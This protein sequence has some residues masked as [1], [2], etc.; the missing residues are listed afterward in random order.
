V[1][2]R[3]RQTVQIAAL[4]LAYF[5]VIL[6]TTI[7]NVALPQLSRDLGTGVTGLQW[8]VDA[9]TLTFAALLLSGGALGDRIGSR[10]VFE[11]GVAVFTLASLGCAVAPSVAT[12]VAFR[13]SQGAGAALS[14]A[15]S[16]ALLR[17]AFPHPGARARAVGVWGAVAGVGAAAGPSLGG[18][19]VAAW[20]WRAVFLVNLPIGVAGVLLARRVLPDPGG[21]PQAGLDAA[22]QLASVVALGAL[23]LVLIEAGARGA[24]NPLTIGGMIALVAAAAAL[25][26]AE[27]RASDPMLPVNLFRD[28]RF[29]GATTVGALINL[30]FYGQLFVVN[31]YLQDVRHMSALLAG[32]ALLPELC[33]ATVASA[34]SGRLVARRGVV[35]PMAVGLV[36]GACGLA[37]LAAVDAATPYVLLIPAF[38]AT[39]AGMALTMPAA[40]SAVIDAAPAE[41]AGVASGVLNAA[42]QVGGVVGVA[43]LGSLV[44]GARGFAGG[45][46]LALALA[47]ASFVVAAYVA[48]VAVG[49]RR[50]AAA[51]R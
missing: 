6:D 27:R 51:G 29:S 7:V 8:V 23:T 15:A 49:Q 28:A 40:T 26:L 38:V 43:L 41:R 31:L 4:C 16:L 33:M 10:R 1:R 9:Y 13:A 20:S 34:A 30:G 25:T 50:P 22:G 21:R 18:A 14:V 32:L 47:A 35:P 42:R 44:A 3:H 46:H 39:G 5:M 24:T 2:C 17:A 12:L 19:L 36:T 45:M 11:A 37:A 48:V